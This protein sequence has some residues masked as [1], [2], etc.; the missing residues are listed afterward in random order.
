M[1]TA[2]PASSSVTPGHDTAGTLM[3]KVASYV[4]AVTDDA[5][6]K[7]TILCA[8]N[9]AIAFV[10]A[11]PWYKLTSSSDLDMTADDDDIGLP[12]TF[13]EPL[14]CYQLNSSDERTKRLPYKPLQTLLA[15]RQDNT[16]P[17]TP[18]AYAIN[19]NTRELIL[20]I[21]PSSAWVTN[22]PE[23]RLYFHRRLAEL[24][25]DSSVS[26]GEP[27]F[28]WFLIWYARRE[29][30]AVRD[31]GKFQLADRMTE[32]FYRELRRSDTNQ[33]TDWVLT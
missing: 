8:L 18:S 17:G 24:T 14:A 22:N 3:S 12:A 7:S 15:E 2:V 5:E 31:P 19:Y 10:N 28:D 16:T 13:K 25:Q 11:R 20:D 26:G 27:E 33:Q 21:Q 23:L 1:A 30:A 4:Q 32:Q 6:V 9:G 29:M